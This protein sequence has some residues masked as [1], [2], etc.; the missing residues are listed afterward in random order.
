MK[1]IKKDELYKNLSAFLQTKGVELK[2][3]S[4]TTRLQ[5]GC[6]LLSDTIN[7]AQGNL[8]KAKAQMDKK[9]DQMREVIHQK[10]APKTSPAAK[11]SPANPRAKSKP[12]AKKAPKTKSPKAAAVKKTA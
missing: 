9:L 7:F 6:S 1:K 8:Q 3:G 5:R 2:D 11:P 10:T 4:I 12:A